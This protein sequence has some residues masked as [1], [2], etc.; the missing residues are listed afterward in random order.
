[1]P[2]DCMR[3]KDPHRGPDGPSST[4]S[5]CQDCLQ[6]CSHSR[7]LVRQYDSWG[8]RALLPI[9]SRYR[10][11]IDAVILMLQQGITPACG[12]RVRTPSAC[13]SES[14]TVF[15]GR[16]STHSGA[17]YS[18]HVMVQR[19]LNSGGSALFWQQRGGNRSARSCAQSEIQVPTHVIFGPHLLLRYSIR[20][21]GWFN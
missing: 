16:H 11:K 15:T 1:M 17:M 10:V 6:D 4:M 5:Y 12:T 7:Y 8:V 2:D 14:P 19:R 18:V 21:P 20:H 9:W 3:T 13:T